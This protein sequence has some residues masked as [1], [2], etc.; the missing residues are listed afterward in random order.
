LAERYRCEKAEA[1]SAVLAWRKP[2]GSVRFF[3][4]PFISAQTGG[5]VWCADAQ[6]ACRFSSADRLRFEAIFG[7]ITGTEWQLD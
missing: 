7:R 2:D 1:P 6:D 3:A 4:D 5:E